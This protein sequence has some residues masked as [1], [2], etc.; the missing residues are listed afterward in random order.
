MSRV[1]AGPLPFGGGGA[2]LFEGM[3]GSPEQALAALPGNYQRAYTSALEMNKANYDNILRGYQDTL[4]RQ[5]AADEAVGRGY[6]DVRRI[7]GEQIADTGRARATDIDR[8]Y[9]ALS[10]Q[11]AQ[12]LIN[13]G[14]GNTTVQNALQ[15]GIV[16]DRDRAQTN[17]ANQMA[18]LR[19]GYEG[20]LGLAEMGFQADKA[21]RESAL[22]QNQ[23]QWMNSVN[24]PYPDAGLYSAIAQ[25][26]GAQ[27][28]AGAD[29]NLLMQQL[30]QDRAFADRQAARA[31]EPAFSSMTGGGASRGSGGFA[32]PQANYGGGG[33]AVGGGFGGYVPPALPASALSYGVSGPALSGAGGGAASSTL[34]GFSPTTSG[35]VA[36]TGS[37]Q[38]Y[39]ADLA[40]A[41]GGGY[42]PAAGFGGG[43]GG[44]TSQWVDAAGVNVGDY[45]W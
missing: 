5:Q 39:D 8:T 21:A 6:T 28:Q 25:Q 13:R 23:L 19:A 43:T 31:D 4:A 41:G 34:Y 12:G 30:A 45:F 33:G 7:V 32:G 1:I 15:A 36:S 24:A 10:G 35:G 40:S 9:T 17:L 20:R 42:S 27:Q 18:E 37:Y 3:G 26:Y 2:G 22:Q 16:G 29:R 38:G 11:T 44:Y 14:L